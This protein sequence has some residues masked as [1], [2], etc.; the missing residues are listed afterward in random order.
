MCKIV[1]RHQ[2]EIKYLKRALKYR[3]G[4]LLSHDGL[5]LSFDWNEPKRID[6]YYFTENRS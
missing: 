5:F 3:T 2:S 4:D 1:N 6:Y